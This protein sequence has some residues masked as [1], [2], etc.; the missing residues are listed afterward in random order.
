LHPIKDVSDPLCIP[1]GKGYT[2]VVLIKADDY[3]WLSHKDYVEKVE[4]YVVHAPESM[5]L[6]PRWSR[7]HGIDD[8][9]CGNCDGLGEDKGGIEG[10]TAFAKM[11]KPPEPP[12]G[13]DYHKSG[14]EVFAFQEGEL[15]T[16]TLHIPVFSDGEDMPDGKQLYVEQVKPDSP[17]FLN[18]TFAKT[19]ALFRYTKEAI[20]WD[21][22]TSYDS[23]KHPWIV[24]AGVYPHTY[25]RP[26][27]YD[28][29]SVEIPEKV[30]NRTLEPGHYIVHYRWRGYSDCVD[31]NL[32]LEEKKDKDGID[33]N[34]Y[35]WNKID[36]CQY[37]DPMQINTACHI[38]TGS[39]DQCVKELTD[40]RHEIHCEEPCPS[41]FGVNVV[42][43]NNP[44]GVLFPGIENVPWDNGTCANTEWTRYDGK[45]TESEKHDWD[46]WDHE[47]LDGQYCS[48]WDTQKETTLRN[49]VI[50]CSTTQRCTGISWQKGES[51]DQAMYTGKHIFNTCRSTH[52]G[53]NFPLKVAAGWVAFMKTGSA[54]MSALNPETPSASDDEYVGVVFGATEARFGN[55]FK[56]GWLPA[57]ISYPE[58]GFWIHESGG[59]FSNTSNALSPEKQFGAASSTASRVRPSWLQGGT[60]TGTDDDVNIQMGW[61]CKFH[62]GLNV[63]EHPDTKYDNN[64]GMRMANSGHLSEAQKKFEEM[65]SDYESACPSMKYD[66]EV[67]CLASGYDASNPPAIAVSYTELYMRDVDKSV[68]DTDDTQNQWELAV[69]NGLYEVTVAVGYDGQNNRKLWSRG[70]AVENTRFVDTDIDYERTEY[71]IKV[72]VTDGLL[73]FA[74]FHAGE[75]RNMMCQAINSLK[76]KRLGGAWNK[77]WYPVTSTTEGAWWQMELEDNS[78]VGLVSIA[79]KSGLQVSMEDLVDFNRVGR[80]DFDV[81]VACSTWWLYKGN[82]CPTSTT[83][84]GEGLNVDRWNPIGRF[85]DGGIVTGGIVSVSDTPCSGESCRILPGDSKSHMCTSIYAG[86]P[87]VSTFDKPPWNMGNLNFGMRA[88]QIHCHGAKGKYLRVWL[89]GPNRI[90]FA[91]VSVNKLKPNPPVIKD[92]AKCAMKTLSLNPVGSTSDNPA[93]ERK[94]QNSNC[95]VGSS[96]RNDDGSCCETTVGDTSISVKRASL[97]CA[98]RSPY[99][100][101]C[102]S[103]MVTNLPGGSISVGNWD[104][105]TASRNF[106]DLAPYTARYIRSFQ[107]F[108]APGGVDPLEKSRFTI[109]CDPECEIVVDFGVDYDVSD[110]KFLGG[111]LFNGNNSESSWPLQKHA[112]YAWTGNAASLR[113]NQDSVDSMMLEQRESSSWSKIAGSDEATNNIHHNFPSPVRTRYIRL[114]VFDN[115]KSQRVSIAMFNLFGCDA[116]ESTPIVSELRDLTGNDNGGFETIDSLFSSN[117]DTWQAVSDRPHCNLWGVNSDLEVIK[118]ECSSTTKYTFTQAEER[119]ADVGGRLCTADELAD[120]CAARLNGYTGVGCDAWTASTCDKETSGMCTSDP[121]DTVV[122]YGIEAQVHKD[123]STPEYVVS[124]DPSDPIFYSTCYVRER[125]I[126]FDPPHG[127][128]SSLAGEAEVEDAP[129]SGST[130]VSQSAVAGKVA[131]P[132]W[133]YNNKCLDCDSF[134]RYGARFRT[135][136]YTR[137]CHWFPRLLA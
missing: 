99:I 10:F 12:R 26:S 117:S 51:D 132:Q 128:E 72:E 123:S 11:D 46:A 15:G 45:V 19:A 64:Y 100:P 52:R 114:K 73:S 41:R 31:V 70:C 75:S 38:A 47:R 40:S 127:S 56:L 13:A 66:P 61:R 44:A 18:H 126:D 74:G 27:D 54:F 30:G 83:T 55:G 8:E 106:L 69:D 14:Q 110:I 122:C 130:F 137:G 121:E 124:N 62:H 84:T 59:L 97:C 105:D 90:F 81:G 91:H 107:R 93:G 136:C 135:N 119:C 71:T 25:T 68:C 129:D 102:S 113:P 20:K 98:E 50:K 7:Y 2:S 85:D 23:K 35:I 63:S 79:P 92:K 111:R 86:T 32:H 67:D 88:T 3:A 80:D 24:M 65:K 6:D 95:K 96:N 4:D 57:D 87:G 29:V 34:A 33:N 116:T 82:S 112:L 1:I 94:G 120:G 115:V 53:T 5:H 21:R 134:D 108:L 39:P 37:K 104:V 22:R 109:W 77:L 9:T 125:A 28:A 49:A 78:P 16:D 131:K 118:S 42:P 60:G 58:T 17:H 103:A 101:K 48:G 133:K 43:L 36:H 76:I 89:P